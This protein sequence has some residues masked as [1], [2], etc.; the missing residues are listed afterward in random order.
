MLLA[1][2]TG[3]DGPIDLQPQQL[4]LLGF[5]LSVRDHALR[6]QRSEPFEIV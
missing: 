1:S 5:E 4:F 3:M 6:L 2:A